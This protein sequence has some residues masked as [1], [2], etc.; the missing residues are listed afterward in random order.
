MYDV[1]NQQRYVSHTNYVIKWESVG[2][3]KMLIIYYID[4]GR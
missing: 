1:T 3:D 4:K 2:Y